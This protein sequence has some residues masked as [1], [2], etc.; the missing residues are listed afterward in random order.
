MDIIVIIHKN[1][2]Q[3]L[4][5]VW[6]FFWGGALPMTNLCSKICV[7]EYFAIRIVANTKEEAG[8][9]KA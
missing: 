2:T 6:Y 8:N 1:T 4:V 5:N 7:Y 3:E 9:E